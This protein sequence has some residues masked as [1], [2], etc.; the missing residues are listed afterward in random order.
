MLCIIQYPKAKIHSFNSVSTSEHEQFGINIGTKGAICQKCHFILVKTR[1]NQTLSNILVNHLNNAR[2]KHS[3]HK[4]SISTIIEK[5]KNSTDFMW[6]NAIIGVQQLQDVITNQ[7]GCLR[8]KRIGQ[9][10]IIKTTYIGV[11]VQ[12]H[13]ECQ[14]CHKKDIF[15]GSSKRQEN[16]KVYEVN[17]LEA[18]SFQ[19]SGITYPE[20]EKQQIIR[21]VHPLSK[22]TAIDTGNKLVGPAYSKLMQESS[23]QTHIDIK[24]NII[25]RFIEVIQSEYH[26]LDTF[27]QVLIEYIYSFLFD[28]RYFAC[29]FDA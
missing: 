28:A 25:R 10:T 23:Q 9:C 19:T 20:Y 6:N 5:E 14:F 1:Q 22:H 17:F 24:N 21:S 16:A 27:P 2:N 26:L 29:S 3:K 15:H 7:M 18:I 13:Y 11:T 12:I 4:L 8:C